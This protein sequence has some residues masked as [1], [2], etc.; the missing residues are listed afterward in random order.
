MRSTG[1]AAR[2]KHGPA[3]DRGARHGEDRGIV[4][5]DAF[6]SDGG[7]AASVDDHYPLFS[8]TKP[9]VGL[10][11]LRLIEQGRLTPDTPL[12][13]PRSPSSAPRPRRRRAPAPPR[14]PHAR[15]SSSPRWTLPAGL[16]PSPLAPGRDFAAGT[17]LGYSTIA[18]EGVAALI[19]HASGEPWERAV[20]KVGERADAAGLTFDA[21]ASPHSPVDAV[22]RDL[23]YARFAA[24]RHP[25]AGFLGPRSGPARHR[26]RTAP[27][28]RLPRSAG[29]ATTRCCGRSRRGCRS[30]SRT[31]RAAARTGASTW[32]LRHS[33]PGLLA[34]DTFGHGGWAGA[35]FW[36]TP[37]RGVCF[38][39]LTNIG[40]GFGRFA[41][42][43]RPAAQRGGGRRLK[44]SGIPDSGVPC[45]LTERLR[46]ASSRFRMPRSARSGVARLACERRQARMRAWMR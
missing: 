31:S 29:D 2:S 1:H 12:S 4:A 34:R 20:A 39:L 5:L 3:A 30:S 43:R 19:E 7:R 16:R 33:S 17:V 21:D 24:L 45:E 44:A 23:D 13:A 18:F 10:A 36:I 15:A 25:G 35:E 28:R 14:E 38:I 42:R 41:R 40:G 27:Q 37:S 8:I 6:G 11:A 46:S 26:Q 32:N 9:I 22:E